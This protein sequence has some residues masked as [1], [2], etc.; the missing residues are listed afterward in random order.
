[1]A[2]GL[3]V[4]MHQ[5][6]SHGPAYHLRS[7]AARK[8]F[9]P[10]CESPALQ[11]CSQASIVNAYDN[12]IAYT[13][14][15]LGQAIAWLKRQAPHADTAMIYVSDHG[16]SLGENNLYLHGMPYT[17][18]PDVQKRVPWVTWVSDGFRRA[19]GLSVD[20]LRAA[21]DTKI[22]HDHYFHSVLGL[23]GVGTTAYQPALD[24]YAQCRGRPGEIA[25]ELPP[26]PPKAVVATSG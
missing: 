1:V 18:A 5:M 26:T 8:R 13:D 7:P 14:H 6:G 9:L 4:V 3:V 23:M 10:E 16:E 17:I 21:Q 25:I 24:A 2:R 20:C 11:D 19:T 12:S 15:F 22:S